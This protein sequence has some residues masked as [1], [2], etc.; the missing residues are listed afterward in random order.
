MFKLD[1]EVSWLFL[2]ISTT[3][4]GTWYSLFKWEPFDSVPD[5]IFPNYK[6]WEVGKHFHKYYS[7]ER[8]MDS[9]IWSNLWPLRDKSKPYP[10]HSG[11]G[12]GVLHSIRMRSALDPGTCCV[13]ANPLGGVPPG[14]LSLVCL[15]VYHFYVFT[16]RQGLTKLYRLTSNLFCGPD[17]PWTCHFLPK[18]L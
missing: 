3:R 16:I 12:F 5:Q 10:M 14:L 7:R 18:P 11:I 2:Y 8:H 6:Q 13:R 1:V 15:F 9:Q 17:K 4:E